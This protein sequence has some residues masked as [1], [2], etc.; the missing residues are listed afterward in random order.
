MNIKPNSKLFIGRTKWKAVLSSDISG[1]GGR[2]SRKQ[3]NK[4]SRRCKGKEG[5]KHDRTHIA[6]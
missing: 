6:R 1:S 5:R 3:E 4:K 2:E